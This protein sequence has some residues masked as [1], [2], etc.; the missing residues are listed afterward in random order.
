MPLYDFDC[1]CG[2]FE[3]FAK[4][5]AKSKRCP[6]CGKQAKK[7]I[8][9][10]RMRYDVKNP[11]IQDSAPGWLNGYSNYADGSTWREVNLPP[12]DPLYNKTVITRKDHE[13]YKKRY[14][15]VDATN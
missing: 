1:V 13:D 14:N 12:S 5:G 15:F 7:I 2:I 10:K 4:L 3:E 11:C 9:A 8:T 6:R